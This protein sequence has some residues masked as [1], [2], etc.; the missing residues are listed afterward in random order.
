M[1]LP[2]L[3]EE[4]LPRPQTTCE[5]SD[6]DFKISMAPQATIEMAKDVAALANTIGGAIIVGARTTGPLVVGYPG[7]APAIAT[8]LLE[9]YERSAAQRCRPA[10][11]VV[12]HLIAGR[13]QADPIVVINVWPSPLAPVGVH[14]RQKLPGATLVDEAWAFPFRVGSHTRFMHPDQ[15]ASLEN[16]SARRAAALLLGIPD[17]QR[18][19][20]RLRW[21]RPTPRHSS[22]PYTIHEPSGQ[23]VEVLPDQNVARFLV[24]DPFPSGGYELRVPLDWI[25][26]V[27]RDEQISA[28]IVFSSAVFE[29]QGGKYVA[30]K[31]PP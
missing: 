30:V 24:G 2:L 17:D 31:L 7:I 15:F 28:W 4:A 21:T 6:V 5:R 25:D 26:T 9:S 1:L 11:R 18:K 13:E 20:I 3:T 10:P 19:Q 27:W 16:V 14:V 22:T 29:L 23:L 12:S 8:Q